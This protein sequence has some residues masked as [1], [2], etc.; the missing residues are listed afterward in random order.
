MSKWQQG[1]KDSFL[2]PVEELVNSLG[3]SLHLQSD[4]NCYDWYK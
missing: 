4:V 3:C 1:E 2:E